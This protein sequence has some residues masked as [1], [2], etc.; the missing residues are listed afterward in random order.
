MTFYQKVKKALQ[1]HGGPITVARLVE[2]MGGR[3][4]YDAVRRQLNELKRRGQATSSYEIRDELVE[5]R[6][7]R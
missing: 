6:P 5:W 4:D 1:Q 7:S 2:E 3:V